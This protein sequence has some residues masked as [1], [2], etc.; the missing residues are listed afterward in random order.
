MKYHR[1]KIRNVNCPSM[2]EAPT[3]TVSNYTT[4]PSASTTAFPQCASISSCDILQQLGNRPDLSP[5][6]FGLYLTVLLNQ[7]RETYELTPSSLNQLVSIVHLLIDLTPIDILRYQLDREVYIK[8]VADIL[9]ELTSLVE[10]M[11]EDQDY[12][13]VMLMNMI[14]EIGFRIGTKISSLG[15]DNAP[16]KVS[17][18]TDSFLMEIID[19]STGKFQGTKFPDRSLPIFGEEKWK[20][21]TAEIE[22]SEADVPD[23]V[24]L[25]I[26]NI[27][28]ANLAPMLP[29]VLFTGKG[30]NS[31]Y[32]VNSRVISSSIKTD[33]DED[34]VNLKNSVK[35]TLEKVEPAAA[36]F[37]ECAFWDFAASGT[38]QGSW[39][40]EG[41]EMGDRNDTHVTCVCNHLTN[42]A[43]LIQLTDTEMSKTHLMALD[44]ITYIGCSLSLFGLLLS[45]LTLSFCFRGLNY[46]STTI[47]MNLMVSLG[48]ANIAFLAGADATY[49]PRLCTGVA[50]L[51]H[52]VYLA[53]FMWMLVEG[54]HLYLRVTRV[55]ST[56][57]YL[58]FYYPSAYGI[59]AIVVGVTA[60]VNIS[61]YGNDT[62]CWLSVHD[63][64]IW[65][66]AGPA[67][68]I[69]VVN[70]AILVVVMHSFLAV[71]SIA[72]KP[73]IEQAKRSTRAA[74]ILL[75]LLGITWL[76]GCLAFNQ[77]TIVFQYVFAILNSL[78]GFFIFIFHCLANE[79]VRK[80][81]AT[82][83][84]RTVSRD[85]YFKPD[86]SH[87][88]VRL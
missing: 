25:K 19:T 45:I 26:V 35:I 34:K 82:K 65:A 56:G 37:T 80:T 71:K 4:L 54:V 49:D 55:F 17:F 58:K 5:Y 23:V 73:K 67:L 43:L 21:P 88:S 30:Y 13:A 70:V 53:A 3:V 24:A 31:S 52:Y 60:G 33:S 68:F 39:S 72:K 83:V 8:N 27:L 7:I 6:N 59:P 86:T 50:M 42:F 77:A 47:N 29:G 32:L 14:E 22:V 18:V 76:F 84:R 28:Y 66:F 38:E 51:L 15:T 62:I 57:I 74:L 20:K 87:H 11:N 75:P 85:H 61:A 64:G 2:S 81:F 40:R 16:E 78:Q 36:A 48:I 46:E 12:R 9:E 41:C 69:I 1:E 10:L 63:K 79:D 44:I